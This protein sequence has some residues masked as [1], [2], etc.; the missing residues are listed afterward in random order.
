MRAVYAGEDE[1]GRSKEVRARCQP[2]VYEHREL[3][4]LE[5]QECNTEGRGAEDP[6]VP[7][8]G[9]SRG[10]VLA[11]SRIEEEAVALTAEP[12]LPKEM[13]LAVTGMT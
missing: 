7:S 8:I 9:Q 13:T 1:E 5:D 3:D 11:S 12:H 10:D 4:D 6:E 2:F